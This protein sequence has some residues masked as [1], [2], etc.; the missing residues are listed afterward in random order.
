MNNNSGK[1]SEKEKFEY[2][3]L[4]I[5]HLNINDKKELDVD[6]DNFVIAS[7]LNT[8]NREIKKMALLAITCNYMKKELML[9]RLQD[10]TSDIGILE[11]YK[12][13]LENMKKLASELKLNNSLELAN[14]YSY[15]L[16]NGYL[17]KS[18]TNYYSSGKRKLIKGFYFADIMDG[19]GVCLN[20]SDMLKDFLITCNINACT[21]LNYNDIEIQRD[22]MMEVERKI[23]KK[24]LKENIG[25]LLIG[26]FNSLIKKTFGN[27][28]FTLI[29]ENGQNYIFDSTNLIVLKLND[30]KQAQMLTGTGSFVL[31]P[32]IS[33]S[34]ANSNNEYEA[35]KNLFENDDLSSPYTSESV[36][37]ISDANIYLF[38]SS[39][40]QLEDFYTEVKENIDNISFAT[41]VLKR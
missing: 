9:N 21:I 5:E 41:G 8:E 26:P 32:Y 10:L 35:L 18:K 2:F 11:N 23:S 20:H 16:W 36:K 12:E 25:A 13:L 39:K 30:P 37:N 29:N 19:V 7:I 38:N 22:Y 4:C 28:A 1:L 33:A 14:L 3:D 31:H 17:S 27:H 6:L 40:A 24:T 34:L 15:L